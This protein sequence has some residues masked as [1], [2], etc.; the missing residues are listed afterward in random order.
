[1]FLAVSWPVVIGPQTGWMQARGFQLPWHWVWEWSP[2]LE[3]QQGLSLAG[4][5]T[6]PPWERGCILALK[7]SAAPQGSVPKHAFHQPLEGNTFCSNYREGGFFSHIRTLAPQHQAPEPSGSG[8]LFM[9]KR[10]K[11]WPVGSRLL[12]ASQP[13]RQRWG[14]V[15]MAQLS[16]PECT[17][18]PSGAKAAAG[19]CP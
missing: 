7:G 18:R 9:Q 17:A 8:S 3:A 5:G 12:T 14:E 13:G 6:R 4:R 11:G 10:K 16:C 15:E 2:S 19:P 1:M